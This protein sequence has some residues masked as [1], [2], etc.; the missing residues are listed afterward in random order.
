MPTNM[1]WPSVFE[2]ETDDKLLLPDRLLRFLP[3]LLGV[4]LSAAAATAAAAAPLV[5]AAAVVAVPSSKDA[6]FGSRFGSRW[7]KRSLALVTALVTALAIF[8]K[9]N[10]P[11]A[12]ASAA[13]A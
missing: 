5:A 10:N 2:P 12:L 11:D 7:V 6:R 1:A 8:G 9:S 13:T 4:L 3:N